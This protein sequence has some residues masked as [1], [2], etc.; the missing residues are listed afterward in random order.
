MAAAQPKLILIVDDDPDTVA[1]LSAWLEDNGYDT[2]SASDGRQGMDAILAHGPDLVLM[3]LK[4]PNQTGIELYKEIRQ[5]S[6]LAA[7]PVVILTGTTEFELF[8]DGCA[9]LPAPTARIDKP[10][11]LTA[12]HQIITRAL[13]D[14]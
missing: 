2:L 13:T 10:P 14:S 8:G 1:Y 11:D 3:D 5:Q 6:G 7:L 12:L 9:L 4:M